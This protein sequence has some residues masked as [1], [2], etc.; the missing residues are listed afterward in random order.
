[1]RFVPILFFFNPLLFYS[2]HTN[3]FAIFVDSLTSGGWISGIIVPHDLIMNMTSINM[4][5]V[6]KGC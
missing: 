6:G 2:N 1:M 5:G 4:N 3:V